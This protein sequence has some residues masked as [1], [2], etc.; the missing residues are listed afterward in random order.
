MDQPPLDGLIVW[1][2]S[3]GEGVIDRLKPLTGKEQTLIL[4]TDH[5]DEDKETL[6]IY[7][8]VPTP[9]VMSKINAFATRGTEQFGPDCQPQEV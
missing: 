5:N 2:E 8:G 6:L 7:D 4:F 1:R 9:E 3:K